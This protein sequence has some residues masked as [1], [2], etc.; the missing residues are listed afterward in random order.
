MRQCIA[1]IQNAARNAGRELLEDEIMDILDILERRRRQ[2]SGSINSQSDLDDLVAEAMEIA[3]QAKFNAYIEKRNRLINAKRYVELKRKLD[4]DPAN[5]GTTLSTVMVGSAKYS[6]S[7]RLSVDA[8][9]H[10]IMTDSTGLL[11]AELQKNDLVQLFAS[12]QLDE[13]IYR[14]MFDGFGSTGNKEARMIAEAVQKVQKSLLRRKNRA[15]AY[16]RE[17]RNYVVRQSHDPLLLRDAGYDKWKADIVPLLDRTATFKNMQPGQT[18]EDFLRAAYDGLVTGIHQ[19][20]TNV[21]DAG[22]AFKGQANLAK[23]MSAERILH[24]Q[25]G[26]SSHAYSKMYSRMKLSEAVLNGITH[27]AQTIALMETFGTNPK[28]MFDRVVQEIKEQA[29]DVKALDKIK[30]GRLQ[31]QFAELDGTTRARGAGKPVFMGVDF[32]GISAGW[33]MIQNMSKLGFATISS[34]SDIATKAAFI[35]TNTERGVFASY[36]QAFG[37]IFKGM[38][39]PQ[40]KEL[41]YLLNVGVENFLGDVHARFGANDSGPGRIA[42]AHQFFFKLNGM[43]WWNDSQKTGIARMLASDLANYKNKAFNQIPE[44]TQRLLSLYGIG[45]DEWGLFRNVE[46]K[47]VDGRDYLVPSVIDDIPAASIDPII[48]KQAGQLDITDAMRQDFRDNLRTK[49]AAYY[50]DSA[51]TA[52][53]TPGAKERAL[54]NQGH[55]R[56]T[57]TGEAIRAFMQLKGF[58]ITYIT[59]G[60]SRQYYGKQAAGK[61]GALGIVQMMVGT[62]IMGYLAMSMKDILKGREPREVFSKD[63]YVN[64]TTL[65]AAFLQGGGAGIFGDFMFGEFNRYGGSFLQTAAGPT[66]GAIDDVFR[67]FAKFRDGDDASAD[68]VRFALRNTPYINLFYTKT[69]MDYLFLYGLTEHMSP[70]YLRRMERRVEKDQKQ[71]FYFP[72]SQYA[73]KL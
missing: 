67:M 52:I 68:A 5:R 50:T 46:M 45:P 9:G 42:K 63:T 47:A 48:A 29:P 65:K 32:A 72:P 64:P 7:G 41:A 13:L 61:S 55:P 14:E 34:I 33:R 56:G 39:K 35:A 3:K 16:I 54:M 10:A 60:L 69:A 58:P 23:K 19:K 59:K 24:F 49:I 40:Q 6:E 22:T 11:L 73:T 66:F 71:E 43:Q 21:Y 44:E 37:D 1:E 8:Q 62:T 51:D 17:L 12:N 26:A 30:V 27:D 31:N 28:M 18:E 38:G 4:A 70:G 57:V 15:G 36:A 20:T 53:P 2:R 25:D